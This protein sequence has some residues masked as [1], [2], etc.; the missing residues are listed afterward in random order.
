MNSETEKLI[1]TK[2]AALQVVV[3]LLLADAF[4]NSFDPAKASDKFLKSVFS[5][6]P[7]FSEDVWIHV[8]ENIA[9]IVDQAARI[10]VKRRRGS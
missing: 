10:A 8:S 7:T 5:V 1:V 4:S 3:G 6:R 2:L 9:L